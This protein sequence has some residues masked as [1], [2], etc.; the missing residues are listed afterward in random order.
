MEE[1]SLFLDLGGH[2]KITAKKL[3]DDPIMKPANESGLPIFWFGPPL[4]EH[5]QTVFSDILI[6]K[7]AKKLED[8]P[9]TKAANGRGLPFFDLGRH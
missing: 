4:E 6:V 8:H 1:A 3:G 7:S 9:I 5:W 2:S